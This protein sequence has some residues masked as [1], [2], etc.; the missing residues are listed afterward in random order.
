M[1]ICNIHTQMSENI[2]AE[3]KHTTIR[4]SKDFRD[5]L[6]RNVPKAY[7]YEEYL[8]RNLELRE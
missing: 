4:V 2:T 3:E 6:A 1:T 8:E 5:R 7:S